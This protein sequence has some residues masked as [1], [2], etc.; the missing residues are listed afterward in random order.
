MGDNKYVVNEGRI[1]NQRGIREG[2]WKWRIGNSSMSFTCYDC[3]ETRKFK[4]AD[5]L[6]HGAP[7]SL[8]SSSL[9]VLGV[10]DAWLYRLQL[11]HL[12]SFKFVKM[13]KCD[14]YVTLLEIYQKLFFSLKSLFSMISFCVSIFLSLF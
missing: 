7:N 5:I 6:R 14:E 11:Y 10:H 3:T 12:T 8:N 13:T 1:G 9:I 4:P 2:R